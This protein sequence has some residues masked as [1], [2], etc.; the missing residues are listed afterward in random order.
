MKTRSL[1]LA[2]ISLL[3]FAGCATT[4]EPTYSTVLEGMTRNVL[5]YN[6]GEPLR[7]EPRAAGG[8]DWYYNF[9][10][11][12]TQPTGSTSTGNEFGE[13]TSSVNAGLS[14]SKQVVARP[15]HLSSDGFV[16]PP[17]PEGKVVK[18]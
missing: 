15:V 10:T 2:T 3:A 4:H 11:W 12:Q 5:R 9:S 6:F 8:E 1:A 14:F 17:L 16:V 7:I 13:R 18:N